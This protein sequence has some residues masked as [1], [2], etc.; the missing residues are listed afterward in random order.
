MFL[1]D[2]SVQTKR[3]PRGRLD[4]WPSPLGVKKYD[5]DVRM[6]F[7]C[8]EVMMVMMMHTRGVRNG[9]CAEVTAAAAGRIA[10][11]GC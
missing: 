4:T 11:L 2:D 6:S 10:A 5:Y 1:D 9:E 8:D 7:G 3:P